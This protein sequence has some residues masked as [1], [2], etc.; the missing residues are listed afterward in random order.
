MIP[1]MFENQTA[2]GLNP[3]YLKGKTSWNEWFFAADLVIS[4]NK[5]YGGYFGYEFFKKT[6]DHIVPQLTEF[7]TVSGESYPLNYSAW[8]KFTDSYA[9][10]LVCSA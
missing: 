4:Y 3:L 5:K 2:F 7:Q 1:A 8:E 10:I 6:K 9:N